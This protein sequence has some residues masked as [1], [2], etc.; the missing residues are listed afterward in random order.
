M[1]KRV[2]VLID[3]ENLGIRLKEMLATGRVPQ[4]GFVQD[5]FDFVWTPRIT[6]WSYMDVRRVSYFTSVVGDDARVQSVAQTINGT[7][8]VCGDGNYIGRARILPRIHKK[9]A[10][11]NK[12]KVVDTD[13]TI[14]A[15]NALRDPQIDALFLI[16]GDSDFLP[17][18][19][20][21]QR[22]SKQM[23]LG[24]LSSGLAPSLRSVA[25]QFVD[26]DPIFFVP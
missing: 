24:A 25:D 16:S 18:F 19:R 6:T 14:D 12:T 10:N 20:E 1:L 7:E 23:F 8:Y 17:I 26:L 9:L 3:G 22:T 5:G 2:I 11:S 15:M 13:I 21:G 4:G